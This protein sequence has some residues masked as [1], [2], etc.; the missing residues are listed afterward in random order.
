LQ[1]E[2]KVHFCLSL[3]LLRGAGSEGYM[4]LSFLVHKKASQN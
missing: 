2:G 1:P 4:S 3:S